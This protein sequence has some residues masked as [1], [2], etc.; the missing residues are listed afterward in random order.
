MIKIDDLD[1]Q[2]NAAREAFVVNPPTLAELDQ[3][4]ANILLREKLNNQLKE[5][6]EGEKYPI[7]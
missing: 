2:I 3:F 7:K 5:M 4:T 6:R 1:Y